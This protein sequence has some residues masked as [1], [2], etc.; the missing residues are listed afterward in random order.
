MTAKRS[1]FVSTTIGG[2]GRNF[3]TTMWTKIIS[4][5]DLSREE[6]RDKL[7]YFVGM[8]WKPVYSYI[9]SWN[10]SS[11]EAKDLTQDFFSKFLVKDILKPVSP[12]K[13]PLRAYLKRLAKNFVLNHFRDLKAKKRGGGAKLMRLEE[14]REDYLDIK[15]VQRT[16]KRFDEEWAQ[17]VIDAAV[18]MVEKQLTESGRAVYFRVFKLHDLDP[19]SEI[20]SYKMVAEKLSL[21]EYDVRNYLVY[22]RRLFKK[23]LLEEITKYLTPGDDPE[24][25]L[26]YLLSL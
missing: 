13:G 7:N 18:R 10:V 12:E 15:G 17:C 1:P 3:P 23:V 20:P 24:E 6:N 9:R 19:E 5:R 8:Y 22:T 4:A 21:K 16:E 11:E 26:K 2:R 25:E 14:L